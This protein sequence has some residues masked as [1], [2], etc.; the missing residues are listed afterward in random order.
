ME[1]GD[2]IGAYWCNRAYFRVLQWCTLFARPGVFLHLRVDG[3]RG[4]QLRHLEHVVAAMERE[5][6]LRSG[7]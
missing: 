6:G 2:R 1:R 4:R 3:A 7:S 5:A